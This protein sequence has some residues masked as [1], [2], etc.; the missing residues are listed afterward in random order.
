MTVD[1]PTPV[2]RDLVTVRHASHRFASAALPTFEAVEL[3]VRSNELIA[4]VGPSG[5]GKSTLL[6][7]VVGLVDL[8]FGSIERAPG[9]RV[10]YVPQAPSRGAALP[11]TVSQSVALAAQRPGRLSQ[12]DRR[13][14]GELLD[15][16]GLAGSANRPLGSLSGGERR[17]AETA[18]ALFGR[19]D[20]LVLDEPTAGL[21]AAAR[22][23]SIGLFRDIH[24][25]DDG[26]AI[27]LTS[28]DMN[29]I[30]ADIPRV[31]AFDRT[32]VADGPPSEVLHPYVLERTFGVPMAV[33]RRRDAPVI[34]ALDGP[35]RR[36]RA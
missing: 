17:R 2:V 11:I 32:V 3:T 29:G 12:P 24:T 36:R 10:G 7:A 27:L 30:A 20:L 21:D 18:R 13:R 35:E 14:I 19:P 33:I 4:I 28:H 5:G 22:R 16:V 34:V 23:A 6:R 8:T 31:V 25:G 1:V 26:P 9:L 15:L